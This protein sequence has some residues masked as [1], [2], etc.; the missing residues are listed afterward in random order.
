MAIQVVCASHSPLIAHTQP[1]PAVAPEVSAALDAL[2]RE[3][4][5]FDPELIVVFGPDHFGGFFYDL[6]PPFCIGTRATAIGDFGISEQGQSYDVPEAIAARLHAAV[7]EAGV[8]AAVSY[9][10]QADHGFA[11]TLE[12]IAG[13][14]GARPTIPVFVNCA[15]APCPSFARVIALG[16]AVGAFLRTLDMRVLVIGSGGL[17]HDP[18]IPRLDQSPPEAQAFMIDGRNPSAERQ[19][20]KLVRNLDAAA[21]MTA[22]TWTGRALNPDWDRRITQALIDGDWPTL[23]GLTQDDVLRDAGR[24]GQEVRTW[25]AAFATLAPD[26]WP[27]EVSHRF[28]REVPQW[29]AGFG[30]VRVL[31]RRA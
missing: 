4:S 21:A 8:D 17:S 6:M 26:A 7:M 19:Q 25:V 29:N 5:A 23:E 2:G 30:I 11:Q 3:V 15:A 31:G 13:G 12:Q 9:R 18:P 1:A 10:M 14:V 16:R 27:L 22:G 20:A 24:G 28:Y